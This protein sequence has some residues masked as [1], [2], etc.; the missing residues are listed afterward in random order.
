MLTVSRYMADVIE[1]QKLIEYLVGPESH[2]EILRR[3]TVILLFLQ[4]VG[5]L[6]PTIRD[7]L[8]QPIMEGRDGRISLAVMELISDNLQHAP[9]EICLDYCRR[10]TQLPLSFFSNKLM[11]FLP[12]ILEC[13]KLQF[14]KEAVRHVS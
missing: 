11:N 10:I 3:A 8:W 6:S 14:Q 4:L 5:R 2:P 13:T 9:Y 7:A 12:R 1:E